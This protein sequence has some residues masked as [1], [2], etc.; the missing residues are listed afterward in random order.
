PMTRF[1]PLSVNRVVGCLFSAGSAS[2]K[3]FSVVTIF[4]S[5]AVHIDSAGATNPNVGHGH[6]KTDAERIR[7]WWSIFSRVASDPIHE[8]V[9]SFNRRC[10][11]LNR[12]AFLNSANR[13]AF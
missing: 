9:R 13:A 1:L 11:T 5:Q 10:E 6:S 4:Q 7:Q 12:V 2:S 8:T 3:V